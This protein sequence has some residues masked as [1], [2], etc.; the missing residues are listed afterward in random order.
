MAYRFTNTDKWGDSWFYN[1]SNIERLLFIYLC[2][3]CNIGGFIETNI[4]KWAFDLKVKEH[5]IEGALK[6]LSRG[7]IY[8][9]NSDTIYL[10]N[11]LKH[12]K[13]LPLNQKNKAHQGILKRF[14]ENLYKFDI[15]DITEFINNPKE[16]P[17]V[18]PSKG[19]E[20]GTGN[21]NGIGIGNSIDIININNKEILSKKIEKT[22]RND[23]ETYLSELNS[24]Y[25]HITL[26]PDYII[27]QEEFHPEVD[28]VLSLKKAY[29]NFWGTEAGWKHK[30]KQKSKS[31]DWKATL[32]NAISMNKVY[33]AKQPAQQR[34]GTS[35]SQMQQIMEEA[36]KKILSNGI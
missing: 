28:I 34:K 25:D 26:D 3:N 6:G 33:K 23:Y 15:T 1:L 29:T 9:K 31:I 4:R 21:G 16:S 2:D 7:L 17:L 22:W 27:Q 12:Q 14:N 36:N 20:R 35:L 18:A 8:S 13:N 11:F 5:E 30:K 10:K 24:V 19:L 32:T